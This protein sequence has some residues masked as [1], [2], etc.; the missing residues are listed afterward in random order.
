[1]NANQ[2]KQVSKF[3][4]TVKVEGSKALGPYSM[5]KV[6]KNGANTVY[7]SGVIGIDE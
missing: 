7:L 2:D 3:I 5:G 1:M 4:E 6:V